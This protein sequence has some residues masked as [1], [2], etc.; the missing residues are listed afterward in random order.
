MNDF[1]LRLKELREEKGLYQKDIAEI[2]R[3]SQVQYSRYETGIRTMPIEQINT[4]A[5]YY[6][7]SVEYLI[8][9]TNTRNSYP[10]K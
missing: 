7:V 4:L 1:T 10:K 6:D 5:K 3:T 9:I 8:G 2:L